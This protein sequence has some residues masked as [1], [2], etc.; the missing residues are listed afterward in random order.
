MARIG[1]ISAG[2]SGARD[3]ATPDTLASVSKLVLT[4]GVAAIR[5]KWEMNKRKKQ[6][7]R[8]ENCLWIADE[9]IQGS[10]EVGYIWV[11]NDP[12]Q[13]RTTATPWQCINL[14]PI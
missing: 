13:T 11:A 9:D 7:W 5:G 10:V 2:W 14:S 12:Q 8:A 6:K 1:G 4:D 3:S